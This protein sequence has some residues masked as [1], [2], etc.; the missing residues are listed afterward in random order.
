[1]AFL[2]N[3]KFR[4][5][6]LSSVLFFFLSNYL[7]AQSCSISASNYQGCV[8]QPISFTL[9]KAVGKNIK[10]INWDFGDSQTS[11][12]EAPTHVYQSRGSYTVKVA[13]VF[14]DNST[15]NTTYNTDIKVFDKPKAG[16]A[17]QD[18]YRVCWY[19]NL[20]QFESKSAKG[21]D[22][23]NIVQTIWDLGD[24]DTSNRSNFAHAYEKNGKYKV[25]LEVMD[26]NG[27]KDTIS[28]KISLFIY[29]KLNPN[30]VKFQKDSCPITVVKYK[31]R[32]DTNG[33]D[34]RQVIWD[35]DNGNKQ[36]A[37][38]RD[39][40]WSAKWKSATATY[41]GNKVHFPKLIVVNK[42][43]CVDEIQRYK[44]N[45]IF[46]KFNATAYPDSTCFDWGQN[47]PIIAFNQEPIPDYKGIIWNFGDP[48]SISNAASSTFNPVHEYSE[49]GT[50]TIGLRIEVKGCVR[51]TKYC[52]MVKVIGPQA[53]INKYPDRFNDYLPGYKPYPN[54]FPDYFDVCNND[55]FV[56]YLI[57]TQKVK[58]SKY[59]YC[60]AVKS[61]SVSIQLK[62]KCSGN[63]SRY[64]YSLVPTKVSTY[65]G[66]KYIRT[67]HIWRKGQ[68]LPKEQVF[69]DY[70]GNS[71]PQNLHDTFRFSPNCGAPHTVHFIN[72]TIKYRSY[73]A[74]DNVPPGIP[75][76]CKNPTYP[77]ATDS[78]EYFWNFGEGTNDTSTSI[79]PNNFAMFSTERLPVHTFVTDGCY[80]VKMWA[81][82]PKTGCES[83]DSVYITVEKPDAGW[84]QVAFDTITRMDYRTQQKLS[85]TAGRRGL[86]LKGLECANYTQTINIAELLPNCQM[87]RYWVVFDSAAQ[88]S[89]TVCNGDTFIT[90]SWQ[91]SAK[92]PKNQLIHSYDETGWK[93]VGIVVKSGDCY[94]TVWYHNY[95]YIYRA[96]AATNVSDFHFCTGDIMVSQLADTFQQG[97][98]YAWFDYHFKEKLDDNWV[99]MGSD[100]LNYLKYNDGK[101]VQRI[102]SSLHNSESGNVDDTFYNNLAEKSY[103]KF[104]KPGI[105]KVTGNV[106]HRFGCEYIDEVEIAVGHKARFS[107]DY[108]QV[109]VGDSVSFFDTI[110]Y[111]QS[112]LN[113][114]LG[115]GIDTLLYWKDPLKYRAGVVPRFP[116]K[117]EWDFENDG[118]I[119]FVGPNPKWVYKEPGLYSIAMYSTDSNNCEPTKTLM[120]NYIKVATIK[121]NFSA[122]K[123]DTIRFCA[124]QLF[125]FQ[126]NS[127]VI[128]GRD[129]TLDY[130]R[131]WDWNWGDG[132][133]A[134]KSKLDDGKTG[135]LFE[136]NGVYNIWLKTFLNTYL[137]TKGAGCVDSIMKTVEIVG[138]IPK[139]SLYGDSVGCVPF[140]T[141]V[142]DSS[143]R[144]SVWEW[145]LGDS[146]T[147]ASKGEEFVD[148]SYAKPGTY[149]ISL[150]A[151]DSIIDFNGNKLYCVDY[152]PYKKCEIK[153]RALPK[154]HIEL[155]HD[156]ILCI[157]AV[158]E[159]DFSKSDENYNEF[160]INFGDHL[161]TIAT[162]KK[163]LYH[164]YNTKDVFNIFYTGSGA[165]CIDTAY[166]KIKI[167]GIKSNFMLDS[168]QLDTPIFNFKNLSIEGV[169]FEWIFEDNIIPVSGTADYQYEFSSP[170]PKEICLI[171]FNEIGCADTLCKWLEIET[172]IW[173]P[174]VLTPNGDDFN[175]RFKIKI[176]GHTYY[177][178]VIF[179]R[180]GEK[181]FESNEFDYLWNGRKFNVKEECLPGTYF[182]IFKYQLIGGEIQQK[183]GTITLIRQ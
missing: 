107:T 94:D 131:Y 137:S 30:F 10:S 112:F 82:D 174:N 91:P 38:K 22:N 179:N 28:K 180:W 73:E 37:L 46:F 60:N 57:D 48:Q 132:E 18:K 85:A 147:K 124:P 164:A 43:G 109:C 19:N 51:D 63:Y 138:P 177:D 97:I 53:I 72:N 182:F 151:G 98:K 129:G 34:V 93:T 128:D 108:Q 159:F 156:S 27:C 110:Y 178:L 67:E 163:L 154:N 71:I 16:L 103:F 142:R 160:K 29:K 68:S 39:A 5:S 35:F 134:L 99:K 130:I 88:T 66:N 139:F 113:S 149:C 123:N 95:K 74:Y 76:S 59:V 13:V 173:V 70:T 62:T 120:L 1:M 24:G 133:N 81:F 96:N 15:C 83:D 143:K 117:V 12:D 31:N 102:T 80:K 145:Q 181:V 169:D 119:D 45:N 58:K 170:G 11:T 8:P 135:H 121:A 116:E 152:Y 25:K 118:I 36:E 167:I 104:S 41:T 77:W 56:Y 176:K 125:V 115:T 111:Y 52:A 162:E 148:L 127:E 17:L 78:L 161:D 21:A 23:A 3:K 144:T 14:T 33:W 65:L 26:A 79:K 90:H 64:E 166:S 44:P 183:N 140:L 4:I 136:H 175:D 171:A 32:T 172:D 158:G 100:T 69:T 146:R 49:P 20:I 114:P 141:T 61:D 155:L 101:K 6:I 84:D 42:I 126:D 55:S 40:D 47:G 50:F 75:D 86:I 105:Y 106:L 7:A 92:L 9:K 168:T 87:E 89:Q 157:N 153:V 165:T 150:Q 54:Q 122:V 2:N